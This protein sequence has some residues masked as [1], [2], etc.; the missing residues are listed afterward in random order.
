MEQLVA[1]V[2]LSIEEI[3]LLIYVLDKALIPSLLTFMRDS[4]KDILDKFLN[5]DFL[6]FSLF[7]L[8]QNQLDKQECKI[9]IL[10]GTLKI[11]RHLLDICPDTAFIKIVAFQSLLREKISGLPGTLDSELQTE[12]QAF[13]ELFKYHASK[14]NFQKDPKRERYRGFRVGA[15]DEQAQYNFRDLPLIPTQQELTS[16]EEVFLRCNIINGRYENIEQYLD[17]QFR[18]FRAD[19]IL[20]LRESIDKFLGSCNLQ[21]TAAGCRK[22]NVYRGVRVLRPVCTERNIAYRLSFDVSALSS[23]DWRTT[24]RLK[25]GSLLCLSHDNF[26]TFIC[27]AVHEHEP[28]LLLNGLV[29]VVFLLEQDELHHVTEM[30][31]DTRFVMVESPAY[32]EAYRHVLQGLK[33]MNQHT[34]PFQQYIVDCQIQV[35]PAQYLQ[36]GN[37]VKYDFRPLLQKGFVVKDTPADLGGALNLEDVEG[38]VEV[39]SEN[40]WPNQEDLGLDASQQHALYLAL[41]REVALIQGP[42]GTG[43]TFLGLK[44][45]LML[46]HNAHAWQDPEQR[47]PLLIVCYTNHALDQFLEGLLDNFSGTLVRVGARSKSEKL[48]AHSLIHYRTRARQNR[49]IPMEVYEARLR[50][51]DELRSMTIQIHGMAAKLELAE[52]EIM[53][54]SFLEDFIGGHKKSFTTRGQEDCGILS[55]LGLDKVNERLL[56][57]AQHHL[58]KLPSARQLKSQTIRKTVA[59]TAA[60]H[61]A[62]N[63]DDEEEDDDDDD[64]MMEDLAAALRDNQ[65]QRQL[66]EDLFD[67]FDFEMEDDMLEARETQGEKFH[68]KMQELEL[69]AANMR[70][71]QVAL[72]ITGF[73]D[74][75][76]M[77]IPDEVKL[78]VP[79]GEQKKLSESYRR[80]RSNFKRLLQSKLR[81]TNMMFLGEADKV[82]DIWKLKSPDRWRLYRHWVDQLCRQARGE[83]RDLEQTYCRKARK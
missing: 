32:F 14:R 27:A 51:R 76:A 17:T 6:N 45:V 36:R 12:Y 37:S 63:D 24:Q 1:N 67:D 5:S 21:D 16:D 8:V 3:V 83:I 28:N 26:A 71:T 55:W 13:E 4:I 48:Q 22:V 53:K 61:P 29:D 47:R 77:T 72:D 15:D 30:S 82:T 46:L 69:S 66:E 31:R 78:S 43:K 58:Q 19:L 57:Q 54:E 18:L 44:L 74:E 23:V 25:Y 50:A 80:L 64:E 56:Y 60:P 39:I 40:E 42:P 41:T 9:E 70:A 52:Q 33:N 20:P 10:K 73:C 62:A 7:H 59:Q 35:H 49:K 65:Q 81:D 2:S 75:G 79:K 34:F 68:R 11:L 38:T